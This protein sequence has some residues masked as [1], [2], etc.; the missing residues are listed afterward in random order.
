M[1]IFSKHSDREYD[2]LA[3]KLAQA[4]SALTETQE[5]LKKSDSQIKEFEK[6]QAE[7]KE[8]NDLLLAQLH[9]VQEELEK[10][11]LENKSHQEK[12]NAL[13]QQLNEKAEE[14]KKLADDLKAKL[15]ESEKKL[16]EANKL[17]KAE[18][19]AKVNEVQKQ[20][21]DLEKKLADANSAAA[22]QKSDFEQK[23][24]E[25][26]SQLNSQKAD[27]EKQLAAANESANQLKSQLSAKDASEADLKSEN[28]LLLAQLHQVQEELEKY[29]L[30]NKELE[31]SVT[32]AADLIKRLRYAMV[33]TLV[34]E[35]KVI[36][37]AST[38]SKAR[39][40]AA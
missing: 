29:Y 16:S 15:A 19:D 37:F 35:K 7:Q 27:L 17:I 4:E 40:K 3:K 20:K 2:A 9:Q 14:S 11:F 30:G 38:K 28:D 39:K 25:L 12:L 34:D 23:L 6:S 5:K 8:E 22:K 21:A 1:A 18:G 26:A 24:S 33:R 10:Y 32:E 36:T 31:G 13:Q